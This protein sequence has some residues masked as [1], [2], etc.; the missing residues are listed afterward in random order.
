MGSLTKVNQ[1]K[2]QPHAVFVPYPS[3]GHISPMLKLAKL[4]HHKGFHITFVNTEYNH[5]RLLRSRGP[6]SLDGLPDF[7]FRAI[8]DGLPPS[9][10]NS[11]QH[12]PSLCYS[13]SRNCL[14]PFCSLISEIN[15]SGTVPPVSCIIGDGIMTFTVFAAQEF[16][17]PTAA[18]WTA[19]ACGCLGYMQYAKL[20]EQG[21][22]PFKDENFM[23]NGDLEETIEWIPP[24][25]KISLRDI[26]SFIRTTDKD[27]IMLNFFI[28][29][30]ETFPKANAIIINTFDSLEHHVLE[31]LS[32]KLPPIYPIGP[33]NSL[34]AELIKDDKVKDIRSNLW[35]EQSECMKWLDSQQPNSVVYVNFG[36]VT[37]MSPQHLVEFAWGLAN[38]E[39]PFLWIVRPDLVEGETALLPAEFLVET[40]ERGMLADWCNQ[41]EVLKHSSVGGFLTH[42]G[43]NSTMESI[44][45]GVA[46]ISWP[47]FAEQQTNCRY[48]K[49]EWGNGLEIDSNVRREDVEKVVRELMEG[50][51]GEDMKRNAKEWKRKAEEACKIG[52]SSPTNL[53]RVI[54]EILSSK[55]KSN[56][57]SQ[58]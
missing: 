7:H 44:V 31:A 14:A 43:W 17:I 25:E 47:F 57:N 8:P 51:K 22:V 26:P 23:T 24:M 36:S 12:V 16:G 15:S 19:S 9:D 13:T 18:F 46:M 3:Q 34:V 28:E 33:I 11:T 58:N 42:S 45:G 21:L 54:S 30:F 56:L 4:F 38:S 40:K 55:E 53:D 41:E 10:G 2:H 48:C 1:G 37:V 49:T 20:V 35:D 52:G 29:Q 6:N 5:R 39:K 32:S 50:E 27:D